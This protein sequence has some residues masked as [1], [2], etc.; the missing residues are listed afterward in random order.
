MKSYVQSEFTK[1][2]GIAAYTAGD[3]LNKRPEMIKIVSIC[4]G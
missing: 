2:H 3:K 1:K 4:F